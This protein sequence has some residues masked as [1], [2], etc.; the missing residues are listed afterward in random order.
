[1]D[2]VLGFS[3][4]I[5]ASPVLLV[6]IGAIAVTSRGPIFFRHERCGRWGTRIRCWK[7]R[8]MVPGAEAMLASDA[9]LTALFSANYKLAV[10]PR[11]TRVGRFLR[12]TSV[13]EV[14]QL[15]NVLKGEMSLV[16][17]RPVPRSE[18]DEMYGPWADEVLSVPPGITGVW[19][20]SGRS[21]LTYADRVKLDLA[22]V[23]S[24]SIWTDLRI[25]AST[26]AAVL[27]RRGAV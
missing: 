27:S 23:R 14:P 20:V 19:Q 8:T 12:A 10:D 3:L 18:L 15:L 9:E 2:V 13:D 17:P 6:A 5:L 4:L 25:L 22:Y 16:G 11:V 26:P 21:S 7:L 1:L 24:K